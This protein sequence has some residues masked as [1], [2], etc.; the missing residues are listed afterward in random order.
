MEQRD[1]ILSAAG[2]M[3]RNALLLSV[4]LDH[5]VRTVDQKCTNC[6]RWGEGLGGTTEFQLEACND[7]A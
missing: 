1:D 4:W 5:P 3:L 2:R 6:G 7:V